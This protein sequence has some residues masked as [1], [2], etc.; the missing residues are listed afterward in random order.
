MLTPEQWTDIFNYAE[1]LK[2]TYGER[3]VGNQIIGRSI[4]VLVD[5]LVGFWGRHKATLIP[6]MT[7][8]AIAALEAL[9]AAKADI[10]LVNP[11]GPP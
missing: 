7:N 9:V 6:F 3:P 1:V 2:V 8:L 5:A 10:D 11:I 4:T